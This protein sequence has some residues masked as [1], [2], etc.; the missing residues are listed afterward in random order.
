MTLDK[1]GTSR[2]PYAVFRISCDLWI[3]AE[4]VLARSLSIATSMASMFCL[5]PPEPISS[6]ESSIV[7]Q[8]GNILNGS[9][10]NR[11]SIVSG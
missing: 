8:S 11:G 2:H 6:A 7:S 10:E 9:Y 4:D 3:A 5:D 1:R